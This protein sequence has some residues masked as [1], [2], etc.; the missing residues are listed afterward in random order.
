MTF[1]PNSTRLPDT[2]VQPSIDRGGFYD[3]RVKVLAA[4]TTCPLVSIAFKE[5]Y[6]ADIAKAFDTVMGSISEG[7]APLYADYLAGFDGSHVNV[8]ERDGVLNARFKSRQSTRA[9]IFLYERSEGRVLCDVYS[10]D[11]GMRRSKPELIVPAPIYPLMA[12]RNIQRIMANIPNN[13]RDPTLSALIALSE[14]P[15]HAEM[16]KLLNCIKNRGVLDWFIDQEARRRNASPVK[17]PELPQDH[18]VSMQFA[19]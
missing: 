16:L 8:S 19:I 15:V 9:T 2:V 11:I 14:D 6:S 1:Q 5:D 13:F 17:M 18:A 4:V 7:N 10:H 12:L 3:E